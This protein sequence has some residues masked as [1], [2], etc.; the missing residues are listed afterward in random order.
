MSAPLVALLVVAAAAAAVWVWVG[1]RRRRAMRRPAA[2]LLGVFAADRGRALVLAFTTQDCGPCKTLQRPALEALTQRY[3]GRLVYREVDAVGSP[4]LARRFG[5]LTVP[6]TVV[7]SP[8]GE[9]RAI[10][11]GAAIVDR[12][13]AQIGLNGQPGP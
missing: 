11:H 4:D 12:L 5:V 7:I 13:A 1:W 6:S 2:D 10:N 3:P 8:G 9:V